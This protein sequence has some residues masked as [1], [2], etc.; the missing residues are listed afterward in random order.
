MKRQQVWLFRLPDRI[1]DEEDRRRV[2]GRIQVN[3]PGP[4]VYAILRWDIRVAGVVV[5]ALFEP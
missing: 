5:C 3:A 2:K 4:D 1:V